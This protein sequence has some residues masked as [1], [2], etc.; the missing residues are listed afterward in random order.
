M[1]KKYY[2][3]YI[4]AGKKNGTLYVGVTSNLAKRIW[5]H[6][7]KVVDGFTGKYKIDQLV[8]YEVFEDPENAIKREKR[9]KRYNRNWK[10]DLI[11]QKNPE[12]KDLCEEII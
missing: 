10:L 9:L 1:E 8:Y 5:E 11:E 3:V 12:W 4:L 6:K 7:T 2:S